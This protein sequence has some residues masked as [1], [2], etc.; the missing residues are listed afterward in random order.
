MN[1]GVISVY[2]CSE[3]CSVSREEFVIVQASVDDIDKKA[4]PKKS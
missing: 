4:A 3:S 1:W 2:S